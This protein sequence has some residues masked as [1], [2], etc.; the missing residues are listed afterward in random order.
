MTQSWRKR[1]KDGRRCREPLR[2]AAA[3]PE[4]VVTPKRVRGE[5]LVPFP[6]PGV[7]ALANDLLNFHIPKHSG[8]GPV[9]GTEDRREEGESDDFETQRPDLAGPSGSARREGMEI[10]I[11]VDPMEEE[12]RY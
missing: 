12:L 11:M 7:T 9:G 6:T 4:L 10:L 3:A 1:A 8:L 2:P 5:T